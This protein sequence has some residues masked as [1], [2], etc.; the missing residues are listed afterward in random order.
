MAPPFF[1]HRS[2][3][4]ETVDERGGTFFRHLDI[5]MRHGGV[6]PPEYVWAIRRCSNTSAPSRRAIITLLYR[7]WNLHSGAISPDNCV[8]LRTQGG[9]G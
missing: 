5:E 6:P 7:S 8:W 1:R 9:G 2:T 3:G 4:F